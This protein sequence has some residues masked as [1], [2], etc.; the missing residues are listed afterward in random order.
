MTI[1]CFSNHS[2]REKLETLYT[3]EMIL[4]K[5]LAPNGRA[6]LNNTV[7][8]A[9]AYEFLSNSERLDNFGW[10]TKVDSDTSF[11]PGALPRILADHD[12][13]K[14]LTFTSYVYVEEAL[15]SRESTALELFSRIQST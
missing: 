1:W 3:D 11:R 13:S 5:V 12:P 2:L 7:M 4:D 6:W 14:A 15:A 8:V 9:K 10:L